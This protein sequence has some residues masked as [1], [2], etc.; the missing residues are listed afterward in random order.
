MC[1]PGDAFPRKKGVA[2]CA[3]RLMAMLGVTTLLTSSLAGCALM[4]DK[5]PP[6]SIE[7]AE[8]YRVSPGAKA[9]F[10]P[11]P[12]WW[13][14]FK[15]DELSRLIESSRAYNHDIG[16]A[17]A[18]IDQAE[19]QLRISQTLLL[20]T[21]GFTYKRSSYLQSNAALGLMEP[22][23]SFQ[24]HHVD[25]TASY[26]IDFWGKSA[27]LIRASQESALSSRFNRDTVELSV[28]STTIS[29]YLQILYAQDQL[30][31]AENN[32]K[33]ARRIRDVIK[34]RLD[35]GTSTRVDLAQQNYVVAQQE[36]AIPQLRTLVGQNILALAVL[37]GELPETIDVRGGSLSRLKVPAVDPGL[38]SELIVQRPDIRQAELDLSAQ[39]A[40]LASAKVA[41]LPSFSMTGQRG[42]ESTLLKTLF[43]PQAVIY[44]VAANA[45]QPIFD[46]PN[47]LAQIELQKGVEKELLE[48][49]RQVILSSFTDVEKALVAVREAALQEQL[50]RKA[51]TIARSAYD[52]SQ[53][54]LNAGNIDVTSL[55][56][57]Q[58]ALFEAE[59]NVA[60]A[61][62]TRLLAALS[63]YQALGGG[64]KKDPLP[65]R[66]TRSVDPA[67]TPAIQPA[68]TPAA[69]PKQ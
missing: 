19:V 5:Q 22:Q 47:L 59:N 52:L 2:L 51:L 69:E 54:Q 64:W 34:Q 9:G 24:L 25:I 53:T 3:A 17:V 45:T 12:D 38:P 8:R 40:T 4:I 41:L 1:V 44:N 68:S 57:I 26:Q 65:L 39:S 7:P 35:A 21:G 18:R 50:A 61:R 20:P 31:I 29:T 66:E 28:V 55:L 33:V 32:L 6:S 48:K 14:S 11:A 43:T 30:R 49:Y 63:L 58:R 67:D 46:L 37:I 27:A 62:Q 60:T 15:S 13:V 16:A 23:P 56:E 10:V 42:Y 36:A